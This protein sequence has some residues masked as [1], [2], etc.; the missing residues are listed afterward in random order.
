MKHWPHAVGS[1]GQ[2]EILASVDDTE[3]QKFRLSLKG[4][5]TEKKL[6]LLGYRYGEVVNNITDPTKLRRSH[7]QIDNYINALKRGGQLDMELNV[8]R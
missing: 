7:C 8:Q 2:Q 6:D 1:Y 5:P 3:W 4:V